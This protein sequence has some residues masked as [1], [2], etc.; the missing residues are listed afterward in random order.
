[1]SRWLCRICVALSC[2][3]C[4]SGAQSQTGESMYR[5]SCAACHD[6]GVERAPQRELLKAMSPERVLAAMESGEMVYMASRWPAAGRRAIAEFVTGKTLS[7]VA[8][9]AP[10][11]NCP[12]G[13][14]GF[15]DSGPAWN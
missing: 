6:G 10:E 15:K 4:P 3:A 5:Q 2:F 9:P 1:M 7:P 12:A 11:A 8:P 14:G 13:S